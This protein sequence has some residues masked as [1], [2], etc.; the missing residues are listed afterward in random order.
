MKPSSATEDEPSSSA[1]WLGSWQLYRRMA[2]QESL[3]NQSKA[4][5]L[6]VLSQLNHILQR[7]P[8][9]VDSQ[10]LGSETSAYTESFADLRGAYQPEH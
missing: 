4:Q 9:Q 6:A 2:Q 7:H 8:L 5:E 10:F 3:E 1:I